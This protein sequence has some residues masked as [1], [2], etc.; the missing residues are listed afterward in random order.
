M[1]SFLAIAIK[2][3]GSMKFWDVSGQEQF[4]WVKKEIERILE[5]EKKDDRR[6]GDRFI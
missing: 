4:S 2:V 5:M 6:I 3:R 1:N